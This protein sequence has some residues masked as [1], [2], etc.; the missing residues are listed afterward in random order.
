M[1]RSGYIL[2]T[3]A[4]VSILACH[5]A[6]DP[7]DNIDRAQLVCEAE[8][9]KRLDLSADTNF[10]YPH[11]EDRLSLKDASY[12]INGALQDG[13][14]RGRFICQLKDAGSDHWNFFELSIMWPVQDVRGNPIKPPQG[15]TKHIE[16]FIRD[17]TAR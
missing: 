15:H 4:A 11:A 5:S 8:V 1:M 9:E 13:S 2:L 6:N 14:K 16:V 3:G 10:R 7:R 12:A 17:G